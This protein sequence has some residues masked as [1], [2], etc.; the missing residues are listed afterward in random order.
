MANG[1]PQFRFTP[2]PHEFL[3]SMMAGLTHGELKVGLYLMRRTYGW[4]KD[5]GE[6]HVQQICRGLVIDGERK[7]DGTGLSESAVKRALRSLRD[8]GLVEIIPTKKDDGSAGPNMYRLR[9]QDEEQEGVGSAANPPGFSSE[10]RVGSAVAPLRE[11]GRE[12][13]VARA[14]E[15]NVIERAE[16]ICS[17]FSRITQKLMVAG[18]QDDVE[19][20]AQCIV[21]CPEE[22]HATIAHQIRSEKGGAWQSMTSAQRAGAFVDKVT[23]IHRWRQIDASRYQP[24]TAPPEEKPDTI[25]DPAVVRRVQNAERYY[26]EKK[27]KAEEARAAANYDS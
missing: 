10:P 26:A 13:S 9:L 12:T 17:D 20:V 24:D 7:D 21:D 14:R 3:D 1:A 22:P 5:D 18:A 2:V 19:T 25:P 15:E 11:I 8:K 23:R 16:G 4:G 27:R 6:M